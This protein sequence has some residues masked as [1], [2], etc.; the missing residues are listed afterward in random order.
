MLYELASRMD[1]ERFNLQVISLTGLGP[2]SEKLIT[3]GIPVRGL[4]LKPSM[5]NPLMIYRLKQWIEEFKP[6]L[7]QTWMYHADFIGG[8]ST[9]FT[10]KRIPI[11]WGIHHSIP[12]LKT[13]KW[14]TRWIAL[15]NGKLSKAVPAKIVCCSQSAFDTHKKLGFDSRK[16][17]VIPNGFD[18]DRY[19]RKTNARKQLRSELGLAENT[20]LIGLCARFH[21]DKGHRF[22]FKIAGQLHRI[23]PDIHFVLCGSNVDEDNSIL[24]R[25]AEEEK[26]ISKCHLLGNRNDIPV[27]LSAIDLLVSTSRSEAFPLIIGEAM[28]VE[29][30]CV[31][32]DV[33]DSAIMVEGTGRSAP[34]GD[35]EAFVQACLE[36]LSLSSKKKQNLSQ[37]A[38]SKIYQ[39]YNISDII[40]RYTTLYFCL[41]NA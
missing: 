35:D 32:T 23:R 12:D 39:T 31:A 6:D 36:L 27:I 28:A 26:V 4:G 2:I 16:M 30:L 8:L 13:L 3:L 20:P 19:S 29:T 22:F 10:R 21:P 17:T 33:G 14:S 34:Y 9:K 40:T 38:R 25:W 7:V 18:L 11:I 24:A 5:P 1:P 37:L 15:I 41:S